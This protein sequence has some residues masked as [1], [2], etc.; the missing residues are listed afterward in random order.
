MF[1]DIACVFCGWDKQ[2]A[3][4]IWQ[5]CRKCSSCC[6]NP[7]PYTSLRHLL[8]KSLIVFERV[9]GK[10]ILT[11]HRLLQDMGKH[12]G[13]IDGSHV[14][15]SKAIKIVKDKSQVSYKTFSSWPLFF[16]H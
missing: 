9:E 14:L 16:Q 13:L 3:L 4:E 2:E 6:G 5:S 12:I 7:T 10:D 15:E 1:V 11:M 8:D